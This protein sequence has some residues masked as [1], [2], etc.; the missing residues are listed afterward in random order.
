MSHLPFPRGRRL[1]ALIST[2]VGLSIVGASISP[3]AEE[4][5]NE[6]DISPVE[7]LMREHGVL[8]RVLL[9]YQEAIKRLEGGQE[10]PAAVLQRS[11]S[12]VRTFIEDYH[13]RLEEEQLFP[14]FR[15]AGLDVELVGVLAAQHQAGRRVTE[16]ISTLVRDE[17]ALRDPR[18]RATVVALL[19][20]F[21]RMYEPHAAREDTVLFPAFRKTMA[22][23]EYDKLGDTFE[24]REHEL[25]G[26]GGFEKF[27]SQADELEKQ[28]GINALDQFT[29]RT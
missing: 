3:A 20:D 5:D 22:A 7:D 6:E 25:F 28:L 14:R 26:E 21:I 18:Q 10:V 24:K 17:G 15:K 2:L 29:P 9:V 23:A 13:E 19:R 11:A 12:I 16:R 1:L 4:K 27:V 8:R